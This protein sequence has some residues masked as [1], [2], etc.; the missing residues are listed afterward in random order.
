MVLSAPA[1][2]TW[3]KA[4]LTHLVVPLFGAHP[5]V[6][7][8]HAGVPG[9]FE[10]TRDALLDQ[11]AWGL[12]RSVTTPLTRSNYRVLEPLIALLQGVRASH[13]NIALPFSSAE[14][15]ATF[16][17]LMPRLSLAVPFALKAM[18]HAHRNRLPASIQGA[19]SCLLG[20]FAQSALESRA[21]AY[22]TCC[23]TCSSRP[24]CP[25]VDAPYLARFKGDELIPRS[26]PAA[27]EKRIPSQEIFDPSLRWELCG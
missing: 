8:Y 22:A 15:T 5:S 21:R 9:A 26:L 17:R 18:D 16:D 11:T 23:D 20:P 10:Q 25:G 27:E 4:G 19:P 7:D 24:R 13:W 6:H 12:P 3:A 1:L 14:H 2:T